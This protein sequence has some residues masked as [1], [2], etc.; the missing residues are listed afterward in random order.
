MELFPFPDQSEDGLFEIVPQ[1]ELTNMT[2]VKLGAAGA[3]AV[4][5]PP[6]VAG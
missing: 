6:K 5:L 4:S 2:R 3:I 1:L